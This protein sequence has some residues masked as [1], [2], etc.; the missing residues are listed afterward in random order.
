M[1]RLTRLAKIN[2]LEQ[3]VENNLKNK[4]QVHIFAIPET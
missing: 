3:R 4:F 2:L 1:L